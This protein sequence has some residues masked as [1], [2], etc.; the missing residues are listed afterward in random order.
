MP[1][2]QH[3]ILVTGTAGRSS[4]ATMVTALLQAGG[5]AAA[6]LHTSPEQIDWLVNSGPAPRS[7]HLDLI[8]F[9]PIIPPSGS[10]APAADALCAGLPPTEHAVSAPQRE[11]A[12]EV[13]RAAFPGLQEVAAAC[14]LARG[15]ADLDGQDFRLR[16][17][18]AEYQARL[19]VLGQF[20]V[21]NA[22]AAILAVEQLAP[23]GVEITPQTA[24]AALAEIHLPGRLEVLK[25][26][27]L[28]IVDAASQAASL[29]RACDA[30]RE[31]ASGRHLHLVLDFRLGLEPSAA[32]AQVQSLQPDLF[33]ILP[34]TPAG[35]RQTLTEAA[36]EAGLALQLAP[37]LETAVDAALA[38][39]APSD[40]V[41]V[42]GSRSAAATARALILGLLPGSSVL[43]Y[44]G[45]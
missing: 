15:R 45:G 4:T 2:Q 30:V 11:S 21:E 22:A 26:R 18:A 35:W 32:M 24:R 5:Q 37:H 29:R 9:T 41:M 23:L 10:A 1:G 43:D 3:E 19:P 12:L 16:T 7:D 17:P 25:H 27:P 13:L 14:R 38:R 8:V 33:A 36:Y 31:L 42:S 28:V 34:D 20:Q 6:E 44:T 40:V 39:A